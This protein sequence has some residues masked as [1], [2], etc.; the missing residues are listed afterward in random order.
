M[1]EVCLDMHPSSVKII[2]GCLSII[3][4][5]KKLRVKFF[6]LTP[7]NNWVIGKLLSSKFGIEKLR[8]GYFLNY[9]FGIIFG[10]FSGNQNFIS[11]KNLFSWNRVVSRKWCWCIWLALLFIDTYNISV[12]PSPFLIFFKKECAKNIGKYA[13]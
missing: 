11:R 12:T 9:F 3:L 8:K 13:N 6:A 10:N 1:V 4:T 5:I 7:T 2:D